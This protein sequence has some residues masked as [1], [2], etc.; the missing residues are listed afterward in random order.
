MKNHGYLFI[1]LL[2]SLLILFHFGP[3]VYAQSRMADSLLAVIQAQKDSKIKADNL[4]NLG[5]EY[6]RSKLDSALFFADQDSV[7]SIK[8]DYTE[9]LADALYLKS[10][11]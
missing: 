3:G 6:L 2:I 10:R 8:L 11:V 1:H 9:G 4:Y 7:L 5:F